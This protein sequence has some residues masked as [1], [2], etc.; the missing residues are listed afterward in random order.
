MAEV[1]NKKQELQTKFC[2]TL[3]QVNA[4]LA[5]A[6]EPFQA[7][8]ATLALSGLRAGELQR[9]RLEDVDLEGNWIKVIS[10]V[11]AK[12]KTG[13]SRHVPIHPRLRAILA[14]IPRT[15]REYFFTYSGD[16]ADPRPIKLKRLND[17]LKSL[18]PQLGIPRGRKQGM[19]VHSFRHFFETAAV[20]AGV[21]QPVVDRWMGHALDRTVMANVYYGFDGQISQ[22]KITLISFAEADDSSQTTAVRRA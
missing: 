18:L 4:I 13:K 7:Q 19:V 8:W 9:L 1:K 11:G 22:E 21:P 3:D 6:P 14:E 16:P 2:P 5:A 20:N 15:P 12:T 17:R 10:R